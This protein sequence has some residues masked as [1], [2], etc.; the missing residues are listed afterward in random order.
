[1][2]PPACR[3][4]E[5]GRTDPVYASGKTFTIT[6]HQNS[7]ENG[8]IQKARLNGK[9]LD[10]CFLNYSEIAEGGTLELEMGPSPNTSW[11][12]VESGF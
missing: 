7:P 11:G 4:S 9:P 1:M 12:I 2:C 6:A 5:T 3:M 8:Y 10:R